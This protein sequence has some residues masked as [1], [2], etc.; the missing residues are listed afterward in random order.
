MSSFPNDFEMFTSV[1]Y[2]LAIQFISCVI[3]FWFAL[4]FEVPATRAEKLIVDAILGIII[5][6][7]VKQHVN[8]K[9]STRKKTDDTSAENFKDKNVIEDDG[10]VEKQT[11]RKDAIVASDR[12]EQAEFASTDCDKSAEK[13]NETYSADS[14]TEEPGSID[15]NLSNGID[16]PSYDQ[17]MRDADA[18]QRA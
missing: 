3:A 2:Y 8:I 12:N 6:P 4:I 9:S 10:F 15:G 17:L 18:I 16:P 14:I 7:E 13:N 11:Q 1:W 5:K